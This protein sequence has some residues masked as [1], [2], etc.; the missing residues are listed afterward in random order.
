MIWAGVLAFE[1]RYW[2][3]RQHTP[4]GPRGR[5]GVE[6]DK[7][8]EVEDF[9]GGPRQ[10]WNQNRHGP[11]LDRREGSALSL[12]FKHPEVVFSFPAS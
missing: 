6:T 7:G 5:G 11:A 10:R 4:R 3:L 2:E 12:Q 8:S 1:G 9:F